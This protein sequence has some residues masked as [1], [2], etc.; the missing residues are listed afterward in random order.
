M[1]VSWLLLI[2]ILLSVPVSAQTRAPKSEEL[3]E[4]LEEIESRYAYLALST[5]QVS[6]LRAKFLVKARQ[7]LT[8]T[9]Y[10]RLLERLLEEFHDNH[11]Q[12]NTN[13]A[14]SPRLVPSQSPISSTWNGQTAI[15]SAVSPSL[16]GNLENVRPGSV[17]LKVDGEPVRKAVQRR[18]DQHQD[19]T[20]SHAMQWALESVLSGTQDKA[21]VIEI[22]DGGKRLSIDLPTMSQITGGADITA[23]ALKDGTHYVRFEDSLGRTSTIESLK[24]I[25][26]ALQQSSSVVIDLRNTPSGGNSLVARGI[27]GHFVS[28]PSPYQMHELPQDER[29]YGIPR[30]WLEIVIPLVPRVTKPVKVLVGPW[31]GSMGEGLAIGFDGTHSATVLGEKMAQLRGAISCIPVPSLGSDT[32]INLP[33]ERLYHVSGTPRELFTPRHGAPADLLEPWIMCR[34]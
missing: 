24:E 10:V 19:R 5:A 17:I 11:L 25:L 30:R 28:Q 1:K 32:C 18:L 20:S 34:G 27:L 14:D 23:C 8:D 29:E 21:V 2:S 31:T 7:P 12:L 26:P 4:L 15:V 3:V 16:S 22:Q 13:L 9:E 6:Q 33:T